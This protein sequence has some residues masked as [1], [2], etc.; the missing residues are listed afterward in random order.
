MRRRVRV[1][2]PGLGSLVDG[3]VDGLGNSEINTERG[4]VSRLA[5]DLD[6]AV[7]ILDDAIGDRQ[8]EPCSLTQTLRRKERFENARRSCR[9]HSRAGIFNLNARESSGS[10]LRLRDF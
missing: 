1:F 2:V 9:I 5:R 6:K 4:A 10:A 7:V 8:P 3:F